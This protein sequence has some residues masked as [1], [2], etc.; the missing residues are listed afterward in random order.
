MGEG[1]IAER[2]EADLVRVLSRAAEQAPDP[3]GDLVADIAARRRRRTR[4]R[5]Q[6]VLAAAAVVTV[7][8]GMAGVVGVL[9]SR[10]GDDVAAAPSVP[11]DGWSVAVTA[12]PTGTARPEEQAEERSTVG[13]VE[14]IEDVWPEALVKMPAVAGDGWRYRPITA[15][16]GTE[17]L[18]AAES[19]FEKAGRLEVY[20]TA[21]RKATVLAKMPTPA[22]VRGYFP[23]SVEVGPRHI[24]WYG[25]TPN[26]DTRWADLW[27]VA[28]SGGTARQVAELTDSAAEVERIG[29]TA[30][31][32]FWSVRS[33]GLYRVP[34]GGGAVE[35]VPGTDGLHLL[36]WPW[37]G[38]VG[39]QVGDF[40]RNQTRLVNVE[41]GEE[42]RVQPI[43][44]LTGVRCASTW[45]VGTFKDAE[46]RSNTALQRSDGSEFRWVA[47]DES[48]PFTS[49]IMGRFLPFDVAT[50]PHRDAATGEE[51][52]T[53]VPRFSSRVYDVHTGVLA[54][55]ARNTDWSGQGTSSSRSPILYWGAQKGAKPKEY[56]LINLAAVPPAE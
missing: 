8:C 9:S 55:Y 6:T 39:E 14:A 29:V 42:H 1:V 44:G 16:S 2:T 15:L 50:S 45:C 3:V 19:S 34:I 48:A 32:V 12:S 41:T 11:A 56:W 40:E 26:D 5:I 37:A 27:V 38:D 35:R 21:T 49:L 23:Q 24:A 31:H 36:S 51:T 52:E 17:V 30:D 46:G 22:G 7:V 18:V 33:G 43:K 4:R 13:T 20:D 25:E 54:G 10:G 47:E 53:A 28:R